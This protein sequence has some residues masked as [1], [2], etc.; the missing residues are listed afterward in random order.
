VTVL[1]N[2]YIIQDCALRGNESTDVKT[3]KMRN[4]PEKET[5]ISSQQYFRMPKQRKEFFPVVT[6]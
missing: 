3:K 6:S 5:S 4:L 2:T 1:P